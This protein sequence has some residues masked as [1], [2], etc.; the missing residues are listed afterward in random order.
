MV[1]IICHCPCLKKKSHPLTVQ[2]Q[3]TLGIHDWPR[4][5]Q[6][7]WDSLEPGGWLETNE[8]Q[9]PPGRADGEEAKPSAFL[10]WGEHVYESAA[11][12]GIDGR[13]SEKFTQ[14]LEA[15]GFVNVEQVDVQWPV[16][17]LAKGSKKKLMFI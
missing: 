11:L 14:Q 6:Q 17:P 5:F 4:F 15:I 13:A 2:F 1:I 8:T 3:L 10:K 12:A 16:K 7:C 9:F